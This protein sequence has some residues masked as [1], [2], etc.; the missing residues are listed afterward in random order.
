MPPRSAAPAS[1]AGF[2]LPLNATNISAKTPTGTKAPR[3]KTIG[4]GHWANTRLLFCGTWEGAIPNTPTASTERPQA[5][6]RRTCARERFSE[7]DD[8]LPPGVEI[9][10]AS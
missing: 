9:G 2:E 4:T 3:E 8:E 6:K 1:T 10:R 5:L 7:V